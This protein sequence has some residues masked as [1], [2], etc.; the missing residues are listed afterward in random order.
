MILLRLATFTTLDIGLRMA[1]QRSKLMH[2]IT[3]LDRYN[4]KI[5][6]KDM[7]L[8]AVSPAFQDTVA[9]HP[10]SRGIMRNVT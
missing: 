7:I 1:K 8:Q 2:T 3:K 6:K 10:I 9:F 4:P 5:L